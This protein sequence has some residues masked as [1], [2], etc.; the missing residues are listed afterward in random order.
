VHAV[1]EPGYPIRRQLTLPAFD[2]ADPVPRYLS[3]ATMPD[4]RPAEVAVLV[5]DAVDGAPGGRA[6]AVAAAIAAGTGSRVV[7]AVLAPERP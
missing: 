1:D 4:G 3:N 7:L 6:P 5:V 2:P